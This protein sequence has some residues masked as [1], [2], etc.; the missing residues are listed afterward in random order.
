MALTISEAERQAQLARNTQY[1]EQLAQVLARAQ[2]GAGAAPIATPPPQVPVATPPAPAALAPLDP[3]Q[4]AA[5]LYDKAI[6]IGFSTRSQW[7]GR[8]IEGPVFG[9]VNN[10]RVVSFIAG[11]YIPI[12][13][14][15]ATRTVSELYFRGQLAWTLGDGAL[16]SGL[17]VGVATANG[18]QTVRFAPGT[19]AQTPDAW[20]V[21]RYGV[22]AVAYVPLVTATF[23]NIRIEQF[24]NIVPFTSVTVDDTAYGTPGDLVAWAD[25]IEALARYEGRGADEFATVDVTGGINAL[26]LGNNITF[27]DFLAAMRKHKPQWNVRTADKLYLVE[28]GLFSLDLT[29]DQAK[30][31]SHGAQPIVVH[32]SDAFDKPR[33]KICHYLDID[34]DYEPSNVRVAEDIDPVIVTDSFSTDSY[35]IPVVSTADIVMN[36]T[37]F[38][39]YTGEVARQQSE[40]SGMAYYLGLEPGDCYRWTTAGGRTFYHRVNEIVRRADFTV[41]AKGEAFLTCAIEEE[42]P[43]PAGQLWF[44]V[45][46]SGDW[47]ASGTAD[48]ATGVGGIDVFMDTTSGVLERPFYPSFAA[49]VAGES[50]TVN[51]GAGGFSG[52]VP[53]GFTA[54]APNMS[55]KFN[56]ADKNDITLSGGDLAATSTAQGGVRAVDALNFGKY[57]WEYTLGTV[58]NTLTQIGVV[59]AGADLNGVANSPI[60]AAVLNKQGVVWINNAVTG[61]TLG[62][63][64]AGDVIGV[65]IHLT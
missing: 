15:D 20:S 10:E 30:L 7:G 27:T 61:T 6:P 60:G 33:E 17:Q 64:S 46:P 56:P 48:P 53:S 3:Q 45:V 36:E 47:N 31:V 24:G 13:F 8:V 38:A 52:S 42:T 28:K 12:N 65:A 37:S 49:A 29:L 51:F 9:V 22:E 1:D 19:L 44:R 25:A 18:A 35:D 57:Y 55:A 39:Y 40:F 4:L 2:S 54:G 62:P 26:I 11:Y 59:T 43:V 5:V 34:R 41:D 50:A 16:M 14:W 63:R 58:A 21:A 32:S 23:E